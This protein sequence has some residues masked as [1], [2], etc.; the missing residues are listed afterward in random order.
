MG[1]PERPVDAFGGAIAEFAREL[2]RLRLEAGSPTYRDMARD[3]LFSPSVL[4]SA[5][6]GHRL[7][8]LQVTLA[9]V[10]ACG[11]NGDLWQHRWH[12]LAG[13]DESAGG[14]P[15]PP[16]NA[17]V[18]LAAA[19]GPAARDWPTDRHILPLPAQLPLRMHGPML[20]G[21]LL[22]GLGGMA[23]APLLVNGPAGVG[24]SEF[25][26]QYAHALA[27]RMV[28]GQLY[29]DFSAAGHSGAP[30]GGGHGHGPV[31]SSGP[32]VDGF[33]QALGVPATRLPATADQRAGLYRSLLAERRLVVL[34]DNVECE[35]QVR[36]LLGETRRSATIVVSRA[37]LLGLRDVRRLR[38]DVL[39]REQ[40]LA[41]FA[42][43]VPELA[44]AEPEECDR[45][46]ALCGDLPLALDIA[47]RRLAARPEEPLRRVLERLAEPGALLRWLRIGD[48][49]VHDSLLSAYLRLDGRAQDLLNQ[50]A[51]I[52]PGGPLDRTGRRTWGPALL[53]QD[54][55]VEELAEAGM[56]R[57]GPTGVRLDPMVRALLAERAVRTLPAHRVQPQAQARPARLLARPAPGM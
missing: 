32:V 41:L 24:K 44:A 23:A 21:E 55:R 18:P 20:R 50:L 47:V 8:T 28:D 53:V 11:G 36:P 57:Q 2:R 26:L 51:G 56:L 38:L 45:L 49:S 5:A 33:L 15:A 52:T 40:S 6:S 14:P 43:T 12:R 13:G 27:A 37:A 25:A 3:A 10:A 7:P 1:R 34:L 39:A 46:A 19:P 31:A 29:A 16:P 9:Y 30:T 35:R 54:E 17:P 22:R 4:S 42:A 48:L